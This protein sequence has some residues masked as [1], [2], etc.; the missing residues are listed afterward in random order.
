[1][2][3]YYFSPLLVEVQLPFWDGIRTADFS[4]I[5]HMICLPLK[6]EKSALA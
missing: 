1:M 3:L 2:L 4:S 6:L 5:E